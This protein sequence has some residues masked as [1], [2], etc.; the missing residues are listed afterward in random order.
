M[1]P[2]RIEVIEADTACTPEGDGTMGS[3]STQLAGTAVRRAA[4]VVLAKARRA[5]AQ[6][7]EAAEDDVVFHD[8]AL[9]VRGVPARTVTLGELAA[10]AR[11]GSFDAGSD[12]DGDGGETAGLTARC[13]FE[14]S[15][16]AY[17]SAAHLSVVEVD[18][19]AGR[20]VPVRHV[21]VTDCGR[22]IDPVSAEGQVVGATVQ[23]IAQALA[24]HA[25]HADDGTPLATSLAEY[26]VPS[27]AEVPSIE[28]YWVSTPTPRNPLGAKGVGEIGMLAAPA[29]VHNAAVDAVAHLG[30]RHLDL[31]CTPETVWRA[32]RAAR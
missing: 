11:V 22:V 17:P 30:V 6:L 31:P 8:G 32:I 7:L 20:V 28:T 9:G 27:A 15:D 13:V 24:E 25:Q 16:A 18:P 4:E 26:L 23:G 3:R 29:A 5:A 19:Q 12:P 14:Q 10:R 2:G 1:G 21:A